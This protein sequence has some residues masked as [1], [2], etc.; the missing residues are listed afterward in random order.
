[1]TVS[2]ARWCRRHHAGAFQKTVYLSRRGIKLPR[3]RQ[4]ICRDDRIPVPPFAIE[5]TG[6][7]EGF[8]RAIDAR[9]QGA[10]CGTLRD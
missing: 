8:N 3:R 7:V 6:S 2:T 9:L 10:P 5:K 4:K 1:M